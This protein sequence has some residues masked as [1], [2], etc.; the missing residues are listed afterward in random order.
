MVPSLRGQYVTR[1]RFEGNARLQ[2]KTTRKGIRN[3]KAEL[4]EALGK[5]TLDF[6]ELKGSRKILLKVRTFK[7]FREAGYLN[8]ISCENMSKLLK[9][10]VSCFNWQIKFALISISDYIPGGPKKTRLKF[11][12]T[13][14]PRHEYI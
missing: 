6:L 13:I 10:R 3:G 7:D 11:D 2:E 12:F 1:S 8:K 9:L 5:V 14:D 4:D